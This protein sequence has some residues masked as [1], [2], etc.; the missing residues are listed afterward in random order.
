MC[1]LPICLAWI[2]QERKDKLK[3]IKQTKLVN[4]KYRIYLYKEIL[5]RLVVN[6]NLFK[7]NNSK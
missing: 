2:M 6:N 4:L 1:D 3:I 5:R 7:K